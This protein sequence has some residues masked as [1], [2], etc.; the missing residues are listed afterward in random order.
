MPQK[1]FLHLL[2]KQTSKVLQKFFSQTQKL[3]TTHSQRI[4]GNGVLTLVG[5]RGLGDVDG[6][7][8]AER[9]HSHHPRVSG[10]AGERGQLVVAAGDAVE[11]F[12]QVGRSLQDD[13]LRGGGRTVIY[14]RLQPLLPL[15]SE[16]LLLLC[17]PLGFYS[18]QAC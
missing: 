18:S 6:E 7:L 10:R 2:L 4:V 16:T 11:R 9:V 5:L 3:H 14:S 17:L 1:H 8:T 13:L 12:G 15:C